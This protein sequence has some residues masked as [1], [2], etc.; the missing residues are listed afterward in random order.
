LLKWAG[1]KTRL[2]SE[3]VA[4]MPS[5][6]RGYYEPFCG[7]AALFFHLGPQ[8]ATLGDTNTEL[9]AM[10]KAVSSHVEDVIDHLAAHKH[11][12]GVDES[13]YYTVRE[14]FN[15]L[16]WDEDPPARAAAFIYLNKTCFNGLWRVN[17]EGRFNV[18][19]GDYKDPGIYSVE[20]LRAAS[21][22]LRGADVRAGSYVDTTAR[23]GEGDFVYMDPPYDPHS[24]TSNF[25]SYT[26]DV[27]GRDQ[28]RELAEYARKLRARG[29]YVMLS[30]NDTPFIR[31]LYA[32]FCVDDVQ[33]ARAI[34]SKGDKRGKVGEVI[35]T[36][37]ERTS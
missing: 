37:Y 17:R 8:P 3:L 24:Q 32:D 12:H 30:N 28:Q 21:Q 2:L 11:K 4:R 29:A 7:G 10:Y 36:S 33:V 5:A 27:F 13:Y 26:K 18:P 19:R 9:V 31:E 15:A 16:E 20:Q 22:A 23:A 1:G 6:Y 25:T 34:N 35:V 14:A